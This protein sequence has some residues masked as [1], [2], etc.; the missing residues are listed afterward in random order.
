MTTQTAQKQAAT[1]DVQLAGE[2]S[3]AL[4]ELLQ[5]LDAPAGRKAI[6]LFGARGSGKSTLLAQLDKGL[7]SPRT[8][9]HRRVVCAA[10]NAATLPTDI[11]PWQRLIFATLDKLAQQPGAT[12]TIDDLRDELN[13]LVQ[14]EQ[15]NDDSATLAAAAFAHHFRAAF[16]GLINSTITLS[17]STFVIAIDNL[18]KCGAGQA[19]E[20]LESSKYFLNAQNCA[21]LIAADE[22]A[23]TGKLGDEGRELLYQWLTARIDLRAAAYKQPEAQ[24]TQPRVKQSPKPIAS[25]IP[26]A[27][28]QVLTG[29]LGDDRY[30]IERAGEYWRSAMRGLAKR[31]ADGHRSSI[32][33]QMIA[34]LCALRVMSPALFDAARF[35]AP[36]L[37]NLER[38]A[39]TAHSTDNRDEWALT[40]E[41]DPRLLNLFKISPSFIGMEIRDVATALRLV[42]A[43]DGETVE[44]QS[45]IAMPNV[46]IIGATTASVPATAGEMRAANRARGNVSVPQVMTAGIWMILSIAAG[47][48]IIDRLG[49][50]LAQSG[51]L[52]SSIVR[53]EPLNLINNGLA[54]AAELTGLAICLLIVIFYG[55]QSRSMAHSA[56]FGLIIGGMAANLF[57]RIT[58][59][60]VM[61]FIHIGSL[62]VFNLAHVTMLAGA[63]LLAYT[64]LAN[65][66]KQA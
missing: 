19:M 23:L 53:P 48:F 41:E 39:R 63:V 14:H 44:M 52:L 11:A 29:A 59:G 34:K 65:K 7:R 46:N 33:G 12:S 21:T 42:Q 43:G 36:L 31:N 64:I 35:D 66:P 51:T 55:A 4:Q 5:T 28:V 38:R 40:M 56:A 15:N 8:P 2:Q 10:I 25:D 49:K 24:T 17:N 62:P 30:G 54:I 16:T 57:D 58:Y 27:S 22:T 13:E 47:A 9:S 26:Q 50:M 32:N 18:D 37:G 45:A 20:L 3:Q 6:G 1:L 60:T 61:N